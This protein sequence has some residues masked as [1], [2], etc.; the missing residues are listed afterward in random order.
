M[1]CPTYNLRSLSTDCITLC[2]I[3]SFRSIHING[4]EHDICSLHEYLLQEDV[5]RDPICRQDIS[6]EDLEKIDEKSRMVGGWKSVV[7]HFKNVR[8]DRRRSEKEAQDDLDAM[9]QQHSDFM[10]VLVEM[11]EQRSRMP[12]ILFRHLLSRHAHAMNRH[13]QR[14]RRMPGGVEWVSRHLIVMRSSVEQLTSAEMAR[15]WMSLIQ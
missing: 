1:R 5:P 3:P 9:E 12:R 14:V 6:A 15:H 7:R 10:D 13:F 2:P 8:Q 11:L 4:F